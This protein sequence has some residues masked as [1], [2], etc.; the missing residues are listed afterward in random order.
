VRTHIAALRWVGNNRAFAAGLRTG[1]G[2]SMTPYRPRE[3][4][5]MTRQEKK[6]VQHLDLIR[7]K[8]I[9]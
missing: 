3:R 5:W 9:P 1:A 6:S 7:N 4:R 2:A 8:Y